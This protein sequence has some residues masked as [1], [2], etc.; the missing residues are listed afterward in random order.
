[1]VS[2]PS[3]AFAGDE[4]GV[5]VRGGVTRGGGLFLEFEEQQ[6]STANRVMRLSTDLRR[7]S[8]SQDS[9]PSS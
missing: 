4:T 6:L 5:Q 8:G 2:P 9:E 3:L 1:M 7:T